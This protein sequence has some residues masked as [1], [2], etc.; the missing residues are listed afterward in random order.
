LGESYQKIAAEGAKPQETLRQ[1]NRKVVGNLESGHNMAHRRGTTETRMAHFS[2][3]L[4]GSMTDEA[5]TS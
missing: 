2:Q 3:K 5:L 4:S 1:M